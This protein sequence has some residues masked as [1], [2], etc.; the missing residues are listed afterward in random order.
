MDS[1]NRAFLSRAGPSYH[2]LPERKNFHLERFFAA[3]GIGPRPP[4]SQALLHDLSC[5]YVIGT[6]PQRF[7]NVV[8]VQDPG[9]KKINSSL[10][11]G[12]WREKIQKFS[13][14]GLTGEELLQIFT[15][16]GQSRLTKM[17]KFLAKMCKF[18]EENVIIISCR[19]LLVRKK[20]TFFLPTRKKICF[21]DPRNSS[22]APNRPDLSRQMVSREKT[23]WLNRR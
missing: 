18:L 11:G 22:H 4:A 8:A 17:C 7:G 10:A 21:F 23:L 14:P 13:S 20:S 9:E 1:L 15:F 16:R 12:W 2:L 19:E 6:K 3:A 5:S